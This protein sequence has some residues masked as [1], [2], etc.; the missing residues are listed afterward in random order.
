MYIYSSI[1]YQMIT[2]NVCNIRS[3]SITKNPHGLI[4]GFHK[5]DTKDYLFCTNQLGKCVY[6]IA[7]TK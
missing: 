2:N 3:L 5:N 1:D 4:P 7:Q 6:N